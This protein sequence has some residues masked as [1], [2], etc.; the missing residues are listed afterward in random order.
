MSETNNQNNKIKNCF[1]SSRHESFDQIPLHK[2]HFIYC[3]KN[4]KVMVEIDN[5]FSY[6]TKHFSQII[7]NNIVEFADYKFDIYEH[8]EF[9]KII[10]RENT[11]PGKTYYNDT[12]INCILEMIKNK[13]WNCSDYDNKI[14]VIRTIG[15]DEPRVIRLF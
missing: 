8:Q 10:A 2:I 13:W 14:I 4:G 5:G 6:S 7:I 9:G 15:R 12:L 1:V 11:V 3:N